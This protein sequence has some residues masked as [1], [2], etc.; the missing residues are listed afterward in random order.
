MVR[1]LCCMN[2]A[3]RVWLSRHR[4][5]AEYKLRLFGG[6]GKIVAVQRISAPDDE[7]ALSIAHQMIKGAPIATFELW[8]DQR[9]VRVETR[10]E[11]PHR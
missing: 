3:G 10:K 5:V 6:T 2:C 11:K 8:Q 4:G 1:A 9:R 7:E